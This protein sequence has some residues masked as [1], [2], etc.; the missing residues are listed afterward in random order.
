[1]AWTYSGNPGAT[2]KDAVRFEVQDTD[3]K[4]Q[5]LRD[6]EIQFAIDQE[7]GIPPE[8]RGLLCAAARCCEVLARRFSAQ[9]D[10]VIG[11]IQVTYSK[12]AAG[13]T[14]R[15]AE[16]RA[17]ATGAG[18]PWVG[19]TSRSEKQ[20]LRSQTNRVQPLFRKHQHM[21]PHVRDRDNQVL[22]QGEI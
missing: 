7:A 2:P 1:M 18:E 5:L 14:E 10:T 17:R 19:G 12:Q 6:E 3:T 8:P 4:R 20:L 11:S 21:E 9:A 16:L 22:P 15:A 13:Y